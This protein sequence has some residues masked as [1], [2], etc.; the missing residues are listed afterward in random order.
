MQR[1]FM[2]FLLAFFSFNLSFAAS[3][4]PVDNAGLISDITT[5]QSNSENDVIDL[6]GK[7]F[8][9][10]EGVASFMGAL[11][12]GLPVISETGFSL[13]IM[14]GTLERE[15]SATD[16]RI[17]GI[18]ATGTLVLNDVGINNGLAQF[19][20]PS[21][22]SLG[23]GGAIL[24]FGSIPQITDCIFFNNIAI[25]DPDP[26][27]IN[28]YASGGAI[29]N[30]GSIGVIDNTIFY[31]NKAIGLKQ[32]YL[33][34]SLVHAIGGAI[35]VQ[36]ASA[37]IASIVDSTF[38]AN[39]ALGG[40][41]TTGAP[42]YKEP[43][44]FGGAIYI[45]GT[46]SLVQNVLFESNI[47]RGGHAEALSE[48]GVAGGVGFGGAIYL[49]GTSIASISGT[50]FQ[51][52]K[53]F[54]GASDFA[55]SATG[56]SARGG[57]IFCRN[58]ATTFA[59]S[60]T[61]FLSNVAAAGNGVLAQNSA[62]ALGGAILL[63]GC[64]ATITESTLE[65]NQA[66]AGNNASINSILD[67][68]S[69]GGAL[70][71][72]PGTTAGAEIVSLSGTT[73]SGNLVVAGEQS[74]ITDGQ[75]VGGAIFLESNSS[76]S[77][78]ITSLTNST[79]S[80]NFAENQGGAIALQ[81]TS[82]I[83]V[84]ANST[85]T[86]NIVRAA[87][88]GGG[89]Y[90]FP[91]SD[92]NTLSSTIVANNDDGATDAGEDIFVATGGAIGAASFNLIGVNAGHTITNAV[93]NNQVGTVASNL[94]PALGPLQNNGGLTKTHALLV[95][96]PGINKGA[97]PFALLYDQRGLGFARSQATQTDIGAFESSF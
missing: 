67:G 31:D 92:I 42:G 49:D 79:F 43:F 37:T 45:K 32:S 7:N 16:F 17:L 14:N 56:A 95:V 25:G 47:A 4:S 69:F 73:F 96:S 44:A 77:S 30:F 97:N 75:G 61:V 80:N 12:T 84:L 70:Y 55:L 41:A 50:R 81:G 88:G 74:S 64:K 78:K 8:I 2:V 66:V 18:A 54:G 62:S 90:L 71:I 13:T 15:M 22:G 85:I 11:D 21:S 33:N 63:E 51:N 83:D 68:I 1:V 27:S 65:K 94:A 60:G 86:L 10:T 59:I 57:A 19:E 23:M 5:A 48:P 53:A 76:F 26:Q 6:G 35:S 46:V 24:N 40:E 34:T 36:R 91:S 28:K 20:D 38:I 52:N 39:Q 89:I 29:A 58:S 93:N 9:L 87:N 3:F 72:R 82:F